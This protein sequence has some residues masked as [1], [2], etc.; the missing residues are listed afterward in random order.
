MP[1]QNNQQEKELPQVL[2]LRTTFVFQLYEKE[3]HKKFKVLKAWESPLPIESFIE[4]EAQNVE[5]IFCSGLTPITKDIISQ[6]P[7]L[8][9]VVT[10]STGLEHIDMGECKRKGIAVTYAGSVYAEDVADMAIGLVIDVLRKISMADRFIRNGLWPSG[11]QFPM[12]SKVG[13]KRVGIVGLGNIGLMIARRLEG[14][15]CTISYN[16]RKKKGS[17]PYKFYTDVVE[18]ASDNDVLIVC[19]SLT[20]Q[21]RHIINNEVLRALGKDGVLIN[22]GRGAII[23]EDDLVECLIEG[24]I[25]GVGL[26]VF[27]HEPN[28]PKQLFTMENVV[29]TPHRAAFTKEGFFDVFQLVM[30]NLEAFFSDKPL[31]TPV[32]V[33]IANE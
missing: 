32:P 10:E 27:E 19:C 4:S 8:K 26:D 11:V 7:L 17:T 31:L 33:P 14:F 9:I 25:A 2:I 12:G 18:M 20:E 5:A 21:T 1:T 3:F 29:M 13:G 15:G 16:S 30:G 6:L 22:V 28:V 24:E 23:N